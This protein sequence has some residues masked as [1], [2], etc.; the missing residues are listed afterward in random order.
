MSRIKEARHI[1]WH[2]TCACKCRL[3]AIV[4]HDK[5]SWNSGKRRYEYKELIVKGKYDDGYV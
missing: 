1:P 4:C 3:D 2:K 5:Q